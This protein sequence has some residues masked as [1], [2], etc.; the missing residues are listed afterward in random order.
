MIWSFAL[1]VP[2]CACYCLIYFPNVWAE[3]EKTPGQV[4]TSYGR[5]KT[6]QDK[7]EGYFMS[8]MGL[9]KN[10][11][12]IL[13]LGKE[14]YEALIDRHGQWVRWRV[15]TKCPCATKGSPDI[16]CRICGGRGYT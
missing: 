6:S 10:S 15:A 11:P 16:H 14:N 3:T 4:R 1:F 5:K 7:L 8:S 13:T 9:G 12:V 2:I